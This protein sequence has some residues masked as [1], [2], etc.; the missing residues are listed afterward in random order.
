MG[1]SKN[2]ITKICQGCKANL[3]VSMFYQRTKI[4]SSGKVWNYH[5][6]K[7]TSCRTMDAGQRRRK[8]KEQAIQYKGGKCED[9]GY[10]EPFP[11]VYDFHHIDPKTK[12]Y[13]VFK[14]VKI[15]SKIKDELDKCILLC[16][17]CHRKRHSKW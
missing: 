16:A 1:K 12:D 5:D 11:E 3:P 7:C 14:T 13:D 10:N 15:F 4:G 9:C 6:S 8:I 2:T 17:N